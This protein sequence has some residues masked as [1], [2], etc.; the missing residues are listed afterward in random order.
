MTTLYVKKIWSLN[1]DEYKYVDITKLH[2]KYTDYVVNCVKCGMK[3]EYIKKFDWWL[4]TE[5]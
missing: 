2:D 4:K 1:P 3:R 5:I